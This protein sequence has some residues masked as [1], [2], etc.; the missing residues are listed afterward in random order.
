MAVSSNARLLAALIALIAA[1]SM[2]LQLFINTVELGSVAAGAAQMLRYF[3]ILTNIAVMVMMGAIALGRRPA[4]MLVLAMVVAIVMVGLVYHVALAH[5]LDPQGWEIVADQGVHSAVPV[6]SA[7]WWLMF[8]SVRKSDWRRLQWVLVWPLIYTAYVLVRGQMT[9]IY[10]YP[11]M[12]LNA[13]S[14]P[15]MLRNL[16][17]LVALFWLVGAALHGAVQMLRGR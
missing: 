1:G 10:P 6:L 11:F 5:L 8:A 12:D 13:I 2:C 4:R 15:V 16:L 14:V 3:T 7:L 17:V 9:G